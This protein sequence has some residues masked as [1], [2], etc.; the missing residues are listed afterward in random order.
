MALSDELI[1][2]LDLAEQTIQSQY[3]TSPHIIGLA[4]KYSAEIDP[5][6]DVQTFYDNV[7]NP[8]TAVGVGLDI[9]G[10]IVGI[11]RYIE[12]DELEYFGFWL[13][14]LYP[15]DQAP[16]ADTGSSKIYRLSD[17]AYRKLIFAKA[18]ANIHDVTLPSIKAFIKMLLGDRA[19]AFNMP[20]YDL[21]LTTIFGFDGSG[22]QPFDQGTFSP[23]SGSM[24]VRF[25]VPYDVT[26]YELT[27]LKRYGTMVLGAGVSADIYII[28]PGETFG[29]DG[30][31]LQP[32]DQGIFSPN[33]ITPAD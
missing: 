26:P 15:F 12:V 10:V 1:D 4:E 21:D 24:R 33:L 19:T 3:G 9:W 13:S 32:F 22:L 7:Y 17:D 29:F 28:T 11:G 30:S 5:G 20:M 16:F 18:W 31:G 14:G 2:F 23:F 8:M 25:I 27:I 6:A